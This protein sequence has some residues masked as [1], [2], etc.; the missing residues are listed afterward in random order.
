MKDVLYI[1]FE[2]RS[3]CNLGDC[4]AYVYAQHPSTE[5][6]CVVGKLNGRVYTDFQDIQI[7]AEMEGKIVCAHNMQFDRLIWNRFATTPLPLNRVKCTA[8]KARSHGLPASLE[9]SCLALDLPVQKDM[10]G[11][12]LIGK[13]C[14]SSYTPKAGELDRI[15]QYCIRDVEALE[16]LDDALPDL[17]EKETL[18][19]Q[20]DAKIND[21][22]FPIDIESIKVAL[23]FLEQYDKELVVNFN[24]I[25]PDFSPSQ[26]AKVLSWLNDNGAEMMDM[27]KKS[28]SDALKMNGEDDVSKVLSIRQEHSKT[29]CAKFSKFLDVVFGD[30][31][32]KGSL[33]YHAATTGRW[34]GAG[35]Q[36][37]NFPRPSK[38]TGE[39]LAYLRT[40][41]YEIFKNRFPKVKDSLSGCLRGMIQ[42]SPGKTLLIGDYNAIEARV[43]AWIAGENTILEAFRNGDDIYCV[44]ASGIYNRNI[45]KADEMERMVGKIAVLALGYQGGIGAFGTFVKAYGV[46]IES[47]YDAMWASATKQ[48]QDSAHYNY[49]KFYLPGHNVNE[50]STLNKKEGMVADII[51]QRWRKANPRI[52]AFW[53]QIEND[54]VETVDDG[55]EMSA[56]IE[57][58][59][60][61]QWVYYTLPSGRKLAYHLPEVQ[62]EGG[63]KVLSYMTIDSK[64]KQY[65]R[66]KS[67]GGLLTENIVQAISRDVLAEAIIQ[68]D[69]A[70]LPVILQV[71]D[72]IV[73]EVDD[74]NEQLEDAYNTFNAIMNSV[75]DWA[76][77]L[78]LSAKPV[79]MKRYGK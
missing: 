49:F 17:N 77:G 25:C 38:G 70:Y 35:V 29:S 74:D 67:Y 2:S 54:M 41:N 27:T 58:T 47:L 10:D 15:L 31:R 16:A 39:S 28:V 46:D 21:L 13:V 12:R 57:L 5:I 64:T 65:V 68:C 20:L 53:K 48:E 34:G 26:R 76:K 56:A 50:D 9:K 75:P 22:G 24:K 78:P 30:N 14:K 45:T 18:I 44:A 72:E 23:F 36:P 7:L 55:I 71:H 59:P 66:R 8:T 51:K 69:I 11:N 1:D 63:K 6:L 79:I 37:Q 52:V 4:G 3:A 40:A 62:Y 19:Y 33:V 61:K 32:V 42:A 73:C 43:V 60:D